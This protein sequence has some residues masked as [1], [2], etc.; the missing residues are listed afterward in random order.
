MRVVAEMTNFEGRLIDEIVLF[1]AT[2]ASQRELLCF[3]SVDGEREIDRAVGTINRVELPKSL[4]AMLEAGEGIRLF[5]N[6][7]S[8]GSLSAVDWWQSIRWNGKADLIAING[9]RSISVGRPKTCQGYAHC[10]S[11][12][13]S[14]A[15]GIMERRRFS[16]PCALQTLTA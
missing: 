4:D 6:H 11:M 2:N 8:E 14:N 15:L 12:W 13:N 5:H 3:I 9:Q 10:W 1:D 16:P 7:P